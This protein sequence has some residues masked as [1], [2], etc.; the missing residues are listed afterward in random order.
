MYVVSFEKVRSVVMLPETTDMG[1]CAKAAV[2]RDKAAA[3]IDAF[4][5]E[6]VTLVCVFLVEAKVYTPFVL[7]FTPLLRSCYQFP[8]QRLNII[9]S[10]NNHRAH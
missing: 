9:N 1:R 6:S 8:Q 4:L 2:P 10:L 5:I 7:S 3:S